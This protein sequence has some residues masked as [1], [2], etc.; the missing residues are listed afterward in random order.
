MYLDTGLLRPEMEAIQGRRITSPGHRHAR[1]ATQ[2]R[3]GSTG[4][5]KSN[6]KW[7]GSCPMTAAAKILMT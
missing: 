5:S 7:R 4:L 2:S 6:P 3:C 1:W